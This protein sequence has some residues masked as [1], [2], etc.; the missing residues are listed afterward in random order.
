MKKNL[1]KI[2]FLVL[3]FVFSCGIFSRVKAENEKPAECVSLSDY[4]GRAPT[5]AKETDGNGNETGAYKTLWSFTTKKEAFNGYVPYFRVFIPPGTVFIDLHIR[6]T[7]KQKAVAHYNSLPTGSPTDAPPAGHAYSSYFFT[8]DEL[9]DHDCWA[10]KDPRDSLNIARDAFSP[11]LE[12]NN[13]G[14][15]YVKVGGGAYSQIYDNNF[16][17]RVDIKIYNDWFDKYIKD[18]AGWDKYIESVETYID[19]TL[20]S[21]SP[22]PT[23][24]LGDLNQDRKVDIF[25]YNLFL[26]EFGKTAAGNIA[27]LDR[28]GKV[29]IFD[30]NVFL[31]NFGKTS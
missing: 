31:G 6:E 7:G 17:V 3:L 11:P 24:L 18:E 15:L 21:P 8:L 20:A 12:G 19:P 9:K 27:D 23:F 10:L 1:I 5:D 28:N 14:W 22:S 29:D 30:Y 4:Y 25:D 26:P 2:F 13:A 16:S